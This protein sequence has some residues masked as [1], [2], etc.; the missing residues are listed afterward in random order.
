M[1]VSMN[2]KRKIFS[3]L[4]SVGVMAVLLQHGPIEFTAPAHAQTDQQA[5]NVFANSE[6][7]YCDAKKVGSVWGVNIDQAKVVIGNKIMGNITHLIDADI[8]STGGTG[9]L[10][11]GR[12]ANEV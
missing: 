7:G 10:Q 8:A 9:F 11:L 5:V 4:A 2:L 12:S 6:Y 3:G 1:S